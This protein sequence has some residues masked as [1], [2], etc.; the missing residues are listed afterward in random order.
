MFERLR[1]SDMMY[2]LREMPCKKVDIRS[3]ES[4][5]VVIMLPTGIKE[6]VVLMT[7]PLLPSRM[8]MLEVLFM[9]QLRRDLMYLL[10]MHKEKDILDQ[11][12]LPNPTQNTTQK[13]LT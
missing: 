3:L 7:V 13:C 8:V 9:F 1:M 10:M 6:D 5:E 12:G 2:Q 11:G 4:Y